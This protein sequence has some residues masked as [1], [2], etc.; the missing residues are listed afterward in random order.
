[1]NTLLEYQYM[2]EMRWLA[3]IEM[4]LWPIS[5]FATASKVRVVLYGIT[6][7]TY[8][9]YID[10]IINEIQ[11]RSLDGTRSFGSF[12]HLAVP[13][14]LGQRASSSDYS[15]FL[16][17]EAWFWPAWFWLFWFWFLRFPPPELFDWWRPRPP[18]PPAPPL[19]APPLLL[20]LSLDWSGISTGVAQR[21]RETKAEDWY[22]LQKD[23]DR[24]R[25]NGWVVKERK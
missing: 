21:L 24:S 16:P 2:N 4:K 14:S 13:S 25:R 5:S 23:S 6:L 11:S 3:E 10:G 17:V 19:A 15:P 9:T 20:L 8:A 22:R 12:H 18:P 1:M 7:P